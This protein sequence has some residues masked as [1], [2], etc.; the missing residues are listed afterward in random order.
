MCCGGC[1]RTIYFLLLLAHFYYFS[2][3]LVYLTMLVRGARAVGKIKLALPTLCFCLVFFLCL[4]FK[5]KKKGTL[6]D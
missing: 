3:L 6:K 1:G 4:F 2:V 5:L